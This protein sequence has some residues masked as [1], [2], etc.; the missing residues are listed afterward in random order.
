MYHKVAWILSPSLPRNKRH[1][2][3]GSEG[4]R[5]ETSSPQRPIPTSCT[6]AH[7]EGC[8]GLCVSKENE[9]E[10][11]STGAWAFS[12][13]LPCPELVRAESLRICFP[14]TNA[15]L[16]GGWG[17]GRTCFPR[18]SCSLSSSQAYSAVSETRE[19]R[20]PAGATRH[21]LKVLLTQVGHGKGRE[22]QLDR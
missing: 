20:P 2:L 10:L 5:T 13:L 12:H 22:K 6:L 17:G 4:P 11:F 1:L 18:I 8:T 9:M 7:V 15:L 3:T 21:D 16:L 19:P 14:F